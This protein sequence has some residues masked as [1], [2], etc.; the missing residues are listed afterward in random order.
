MYK[1]RELIDIDHA[2]PIDEQCQDILTNWEIVCE[3]NDFHKDFVSQSEWDKWVEYRKGVDEHLVK[4][5]SEPVGKIFNYLIPLNTR[6]NG[7]DRR[8]VKAE[9]EENHKKTLEQEA[10]EL[11]L[12]QEKQ[13]KEAKPSQGLLSKL[14]K[15][16]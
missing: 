7:A 13:E 11:A 3:E 4:L 6:I 16:R 9:W 2:K 12:L 5:S 8:D 15:W 14:L 1:Y 10:K